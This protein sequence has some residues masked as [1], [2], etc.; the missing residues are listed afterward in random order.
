M[1]TKY[2]I[3]IDNIKNILN[4]SFT[5]I[6]NMN[7]ISDMFNTL[8]KTHTQQE[9]VYTISKN[10]KDIIV[11]N[12][13]INIDSSSGYIYIID[14][15][16]EDIKFIIKYP[17][18]NNE[19][20]DIIREGNIG[21]KSINKIRNIIPNFVYTF[22]IFNCPSEY[23]NIL[24]IKEDNKK[25]KTPFIIM[26]NI[27]GNNLTCLLQNNILSF[28]EYLNIFVQILF[29]LEIAQ[30]NISFCHFDLHTA[31]IIGRQ[32]NK[33]ISYNIYM[34]NIT[35]TINCVKYL[36]VI[37]DFGLSSVKY[38][39][40]NIG[41]TDFPQLGMMHYL[42]QGV[43]M[44]KFLFYSLNYS[45]DR[46]KSNILHLFEFFGK[47]DPY[48]VIYN[49][50]IYN[51][52]NT[53]KKGVKNYVKK[54]SFSKVAHLT[55]F[56][57]IRW[58]IHHDRYKKYFSNSITIS[59]RKIYK[60][61]EYNHKDI[62][63]NKIFNTHQTGT[64]NIIYLVNKY[65]HTEKSYILS[66]YNIHILSKYN[67]ILQDKVIKD[68]I[69]IIKTYI[70]YNKNLL[71][72]IDNKRLSYYKNIKL[73][74]INIIQKLSK[75]ILNIKIDSKRFKNKHNII[76]LIDSFNKNSE[77]FNI[78]EP[79]I[80]IVYTIKEIKLNNIYEIF[81]TQFLSSK[82]YNIY[83]TYIL[84]IIKTKRWINTLLG[85]IK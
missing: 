17:Q 78:I 52:T 71:I 62:V 14:I 65:I 31:N 56:E 16:T 48:K 61:I 68:K 30:R 51:L 63:Y 54:I 32:I 37:I 35:Y 49:N 70:K 59:N 67:N 39:N 19:Y 9:G 82:Y 25:H 73:P 34:D 7:A 4:N 55:P 6:H 5:D 53:I 18:N 20:Y 47:D 24:H 26:E 11:Y 40:K 60:C 15:F 43:D 84:I 22:N 33:D 3:N 42:I 80:Q 36:P 57:F 13:K 46:L 29:A 76:K 23:N 28:K 44:Y 45:S 21:L 50:S 10:I 83:I 69:Y 27:P 66:E 75:K 38:D 77:F 8:L 85:I 2:N 58:I 72:D 81:L 1:N 12:T 64:L 79:Y 74:N 41:S